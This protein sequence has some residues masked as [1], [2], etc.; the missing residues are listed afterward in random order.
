LA[1][2]F[3]MIATD[4][5]LVVLFYEGDGQIVRLQLK[6]LIIA[7][8]NCLMPTWGLGADFGPLPFLH[9]DGQV[10]DC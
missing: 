7:I 1:Q 2:R 5:G 10:L 4:S 3:E 8:D 6:A 9:F